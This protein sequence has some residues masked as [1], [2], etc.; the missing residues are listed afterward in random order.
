[1][2]A[3]LLAATIEAEAICAKYATFKPP[4]ALA[5]EK[6]CGDDCSHRT[7]EKFANGDGVERDFDAAEYFL[8][9]AEEQMA[10][11]EFTGMM[12]HL[13]AMRR[14]EENENLDFCD[15][16]TS[17]YGS[18]Y[19]ANLE[20]DRVMPRLETKL[21]S[22]ETSS[23]LRERGRAYAK[24]EAE[25]I[26]ELS[27]GGTG[28]VAFSLGAEIDQMD[29]LIAS[30]ERWSKER[31]PAADPAITKR[32][33]AELNA[34]YR[35]ALDGIDSAGE[36][37]M[38]GKTLLRDAQRAW[39][40]YRDAF[41]AHYAERWRGAAGHEALRSEIITQLTRERTKELRE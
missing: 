29:R 6:E 40:A 13:Q 3:L 30:L 38:D 39:I 25:R 36:D 14:G 11:A 10:Y 41:A 26:G 5:A 12:E 23:A 16:V 2:L 21:A 1:M 34:A 15:F 22:L 33:D 20:Y 24:R 7:A 27:R 8:C 18:T 9:R 37:G 4:A 31:A 35:D 19:C 32:A 28:Y 17:G